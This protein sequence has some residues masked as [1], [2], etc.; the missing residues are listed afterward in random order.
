M[1]L[2]DGLDA[3]E[4]IGVMGGTGVEQLDGLTNFRKQTVSTPFGVPSADITI[5][6]LGDQEILF[7]PRH[8]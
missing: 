6:S 5:G 8:M 2:V 1:M 7:L 3:P 4:V